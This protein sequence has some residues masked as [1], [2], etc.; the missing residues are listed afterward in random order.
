MLLLSVQLIL[1]IYE[2]IRNW[3][4]T[5]SWAEVTKW[6]SCIGDEFPLQYFAVYDR[7][8]SFTKV[9]SNL[10]QLLDLYLG[11]VFNIHF[12]LLAHSWVIARVKSGLNCI[13]VEYAEFFEHDQP[14]CAVLFLFVRKLAI[15]ERE[16]LILL[17]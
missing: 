12:L 17:V 8:Q 14:S 4:T 7:H 6:S 16:A 15:I 11:I 9:M 2:K 5:L 1:L 3:I 10:I 13:T